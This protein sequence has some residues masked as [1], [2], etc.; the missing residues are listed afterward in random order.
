[1]RWEQI[2]DRM[3]A[4]DRHEKM[5]KEERMGHPLPEDYPDRP[6]SNYRFMSDVYEDIT[7][8]RLS[9]DRHWPLSENLNREHAASHILQLDVQM[10]KLKELYYLSKSGADLKERLTKLA[11]TCVRALQEVKALNRLP[12]A[13]KKY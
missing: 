4:I 1:M 6:Y 2:A 3:R 12:P 11:A 10:Q 7:E 8:E 5:L 13:E 9:Q